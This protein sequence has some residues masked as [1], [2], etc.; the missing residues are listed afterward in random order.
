MDGPW[1]LGLD[2]PRYLP[3]LTH[4]DNRNLRET[5]Y[6]A[7]VSRASS[8]DLDNRELIEEILQLRLEQ[9]KRLGYAH[10][11]DRSLASKMARDVDAVEGLLE[12][13]R[14][15]A[16]PAAER[17][18]ADLKDC[19]RRHGAPE[20]ADLAAWDISYWSERLR[21]ERFDLDQKRCAP[22]SHCLRFLTGCSASAGASSMLRSVP[23]T[24]R[25]RS[26]TTMFVS[27][28]FCSIKHR[29]RRSTSTLLAVLPANAEAHGWMNASGAARRPMVCPCC[30]LPI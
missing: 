19:A 30:P 11:A 29:W 8:G 13:L 20:A 17:E 28:G 2:M 26:G 18:L 21:K 25:L 5:A 12:E 6:R 23:L 14:S 24:V 3:F 10:W 1:L 15:A 16:Y 9:A 7:H 22:G 27:S 4:A